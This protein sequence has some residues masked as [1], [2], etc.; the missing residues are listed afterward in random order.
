MPSTYLDLLIALTIVVSAITL[1]CVA[2]VLGLQAGFQGD[3][4]QAAELRDES[5]Q[6][7][8][9]LVETLSGVNNVASKA[10]VELLRRQCESFRTATLEHQQ[11]ISALADRISKARADVQTREQEQ[12]EL[13]VVSEEDRA[14][15]SQ[16]LTLY[17]EGSSESIALEQKLAE[18]L[19]S[20][21]VMASEAVMTSSQQ[22][23]FAELSNALTQ[24]SAQ[25]RDVIIDYQN[26][27]ERL[28]TLNARFS[29]LE[30]EY[31]KLIEQ[32]LAG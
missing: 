14:A 7:E 30:S 8:N 21:D 24:A 29:D 4:A 20:L 5:Q 10:H 17:N 1:P 6:L 2:Y 11:I 15:I 9:K 32:Q 25:L 31:S 13:R 18:S 3:D 12:Q 23:V 27:N 28:T 22:A 26:A 19:R 16:T